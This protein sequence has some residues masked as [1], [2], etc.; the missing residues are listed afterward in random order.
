MRTEIVV[1]GSRGL[2]R[3]AFQ[4]EC[5]VSSLVAR[6]SD[7]GVVAVV[8]MLGG[9]CHGVGQDADMDEVVLGFVVFDSEE[10][11]SHH[12]RTRLGYCGYMGTALNRTPLVI[13]GH[14]V[15][16]VVEEV[17]Q[18]GG[19]DTLL[20]KMLVKRKDQILYGCSLEMDVW[21][22]IVEDDSLESLAEKSQL[23]QE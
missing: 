17:G 12:S 6:S 2:G 22:Q 20:G 1:G 3:R 10:K 9:S 11:D 18:K 14:C 19:L 16:V 4:L 23:A 13:E 15:T 5:W 21:L 7:A 8:D